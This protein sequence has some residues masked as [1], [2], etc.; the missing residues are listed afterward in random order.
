[1]TVPVTTKNETTFEHLHVTWMLFT[2]II[3]GRS[4]NWTRNN[5]MQKPL[6]FR[7][8]NYFERLYKCIDTVQSGRRIAQQHLLRAA[9]V[10]LA[11]M[12]TRNMYIPSTCFKP[13]VIVLRGGHY[14]DLL[15]DDGP[16]PWSSCPGSSQARSPLTAALELW[17]KR[18]CRQSKS[19]GRRTL[20]PDTLLIIDSLV[21]LLC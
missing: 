12:N 9:D 1:M 6:M 4:L 14:D 17:L 21:S 3:I 8:C 18:Q 15:Q 20:R 19:C 5:R 11:I 7:Q 13:W 16:L 10:E 2:N